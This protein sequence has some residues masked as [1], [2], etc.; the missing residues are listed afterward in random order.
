MIMSRILRIIRRLKSLL[1]SLIFIDQ[2]I[3]EIKINQGKILASLKSTPGSI[4]DIADFEFKVFSQWG[5]DGIL[6]LLTSVLEIKNKTFI[7][8]GVESFTESNCRFLLMNDNW[9]GF[10][11]DG[12]SRN[13][14]N[15]KN[16][17]Y[18]WK[19]D[20]VGYTSF[21]TPQNIDSVLAKSGFDQD[22]GILSIDIDG[23]DY[24]V[25][26][27]ISFYKPRILIVEYNAL[28]GP[29]NSITVPLNNS[30]VRRNAHWSNLY[31]GASLSA[32]SYL[33][34]LKGYSLVGVGSNGVNAFFVRDDVLSKSILN[35]VDPAS[36]YKE[37][38]FTE[39]RDK[40]YD[41][42]FIR[43]SDRISLL[44]GLKFHDV[45]KNCDFYF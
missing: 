25:L 27:A 33:A 11:I 17:Y 12:S 44:K 37:S 16:S 38:L 13:I 14:L 1:R 45:I 8:F 32:L 39:S 21:V 29:H 35:A 34:G 7:E 10:V 42:T 9:R 19:Y 6:Q 24:Y 22:L 2:T 30:F 20:I 43:G 23:M 41:L 15:L 40:N 31:F 3:D 26:E 18:Y 36:A 28:L 5:E 4:N